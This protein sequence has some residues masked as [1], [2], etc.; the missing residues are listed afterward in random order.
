M[1]TKALASQIANA[2]FDMA[3]SEP[4]RCIVKDR[5]EAMV[6]GV[7]EKTTAKEWANVYAHQGLGLSGLNQAQESAAV[8]PLPYKGVSSEMLRLNELT[9]QV[10]DQGRLLNRFS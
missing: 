2:V 10:L 3:D 7:L 1:D 9:R 5:I 6:I 8:M 4:D